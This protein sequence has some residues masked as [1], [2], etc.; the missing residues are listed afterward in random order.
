MTDKAALIIDEDRSHCK[1]VALAM[2]EI[3]KEISSTSNPYAAIETLKS[4]PESII[5][6]DIKFSM[7]E[8]M[9]LVEHISELSNVSQIIICSS[10]L[11]QVQKKQL[12]K[13]GVQHFFEKPLQIDVLKNTVRKLI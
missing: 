1:G 7:M 2:K 5:I 12:M 11:T 3:F 13:I 9:E 6:T 10:F 4:K 8:G